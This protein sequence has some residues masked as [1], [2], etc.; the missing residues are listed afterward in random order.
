MLV[1]LVLVWLVSREPLFPCP[2]FATTVFKRYWDMGRALH[3]IL[4]TGSGSF[5]H[6]FGVYGFQG[7]QDPEH[8]LSLSCSFKLFYVR[9]EPWVMASFFLLQETSMFCN[10]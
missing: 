8:L 3:A 4:P 9:S 2:P 10:W 6:I 5:A 7:D 1:L